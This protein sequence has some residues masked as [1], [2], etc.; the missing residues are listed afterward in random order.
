MNLTEQTVKDQKYGTNSKLIKEEFLGSI[1]VKESHYKPE[2]TF[3]K[4]HTNKKKVESQ[5]QSEED[6]DYSGF[7]DEQDN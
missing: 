5:R 3:D 6:D 2:E 7:E 4:K 1:K